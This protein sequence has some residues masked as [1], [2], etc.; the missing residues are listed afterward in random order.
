MDYSLLVGVEHRPA[1]AFPAELSITN[2][3]SLFKTEN[4]AFRSV[5]ENGRPLDTVYYI[6]IIDILQPYNMWKKMEH[7]LKSIT[8]SSSEISCVD[9]MTYSK[10]FQEF[11]RNNTASV[12]SMEAQ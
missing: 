3:P 11:I 2:S 10:R 8:E 9:P 12:I 5:D 1:L 6:G 7:A 4:G